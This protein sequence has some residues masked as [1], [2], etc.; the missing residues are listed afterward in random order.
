MLGVALA[1]AGLSACDAPSAP[2]GDAPKPSAVVSA[3]ASAPAP[4]LSATA[5]PAASV[6]A[7]AGFEG[8]WEGGYEA[9]KATVAVPA[10]APPVGKGDDAK[11]AIGKGHVKLA[12][13]ATGEVTGK[14]DGALGPA[15]LHGTTEGDLVRASLVPD[16]MRAPGAMTGVLVGILKGAT[17][18]AEIRVAGATADVVREA[19][20]VLTR[21]AK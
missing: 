19:P 7:P 5:A 9:K 12:I 18:E 16:D 21:A 6:A 15:T 2:S 8:A 10:K 20:V 3:A 13:T 1:C 17:I 4:V 11:A 14:V